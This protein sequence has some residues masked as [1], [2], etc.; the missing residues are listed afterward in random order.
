MNFGPLDNSR[1]TVRHLVELM[2][3]AFSSPIGWVETDG[4]QPREMQ[5]L[6]LDCSVARKY[7]G[8]TDRLVGLS[9]I[10]ATA[11]WYQAYVRGDD[12]GANMIKVI[13]ERLAA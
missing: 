13:E 4:P 1:T 2:Q 3:E 11:D 8:F 6:A 5:T 10:K 12:M 9:A 7:L